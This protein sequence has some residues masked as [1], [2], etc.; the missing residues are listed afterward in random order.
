M[1]SLFHRA[2]IKNEK[3]RYFFAS[4]PLG[5]RPVRRSTRAR[6]RRWENQRMLSSS[7]HI[8]YIFRGRLSESERLQTY[9]VTFNVFLG[10]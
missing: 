10:Y 9:E 4:R 5:R 6:L 1:V 8:Y 7:V 3:V 2:T